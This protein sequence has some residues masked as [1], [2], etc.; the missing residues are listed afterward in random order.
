MAEPEEMTITKALVDLKLL[1]KRIKKTIVGAAFITAVRGQE[2]KTMHGP[3][4]EDMEKQ[5]KG[6]AKSIEDLIE[7]RKVIKS[8][9]VNSNANT[10]VNIGEKK[11]TVAEAIERKNSISYEKEWISVMRDNLSTV[12]Q[13]MEGSNAQVEMEGIKLMNSLAERGTEEV[14]IKTVL[15]GLR[16]V[17]GVALF[18][19][20]DLIEFIKKREMAVDTFEADVDRVLSE[21]NAITKITV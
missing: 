9:I 7:R 10:T 16:E 18:D 15:E 8:A 21:S 3:S 14:A 19:P 13:R 2:S 4:K 11:F 6:D 17:N 5:I 20:L 12:T 1:D